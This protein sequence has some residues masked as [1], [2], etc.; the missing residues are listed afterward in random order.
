MDDISS[1]LRRLV[2]GEESHRHRLTYFGKACEAVLD[3]RA[4][5]PQYQTVVHKRARQDLH[6]WTPTLSVVATRRT[7]GI[8]P[9]EPHIRWRSLP[10]EVLSYRPLDYM[11][12]ELNAALRELD[13]VWQTP[14]ADYRDRIDAATARL[15]IGRWDG[16]RRR[17]KLWNG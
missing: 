9:G 8:P 1:R 3:G 13:E 11:S 7:L 16:T 6:R 10:A 12:L 5:W 14:T 4:T 17:E 15:V 2:D